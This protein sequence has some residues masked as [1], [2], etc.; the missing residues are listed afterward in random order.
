MSFDKGSSDSCKVVKSFRDLI[1]WQRAI[2]MVTECYGLTLQFPES[3][4]FGLTNQ[5]RRASVSVP[6]NIAEGHARG[7]TKAFLNHLWIANGSLAEVDTQIALGIQLGF[8]TM[9][10]A[11]SA[12]KLVDEVGRM[13]AGLRRSLQ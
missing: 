5:L 11:S 7:S 1:V 13:L 12:L 4:R 6:S 2:E 3:E 10:S 9:E 8:V